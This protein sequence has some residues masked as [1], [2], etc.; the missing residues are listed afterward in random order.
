M[1]SKI[2]PQPQRDGLGPHRGKLCPLKFITKINITRSG[3]RFIRGFVHV[4]VSSEFSEGIFPHKFC[5]DLWGI[6][7]RLAGMWLAVCHIDVNRYDVWD[8]S[9][10]LFVSNWFDFKEYAISSAGPLCSAI[11]IRAL[12]VYPKTCAKFPIVSFRENKQQWDIT[13]CELPF[14]GFIIYCQ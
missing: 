7:L 5:D 3:T 13:S 14:R 2:Q 11:A 8:D 12:F 6:F 4:C 10:D 1:S 9:Y